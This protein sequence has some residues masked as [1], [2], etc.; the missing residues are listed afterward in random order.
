MVKKALMSAKIIRPRSNIPPTT[1]TTIHIMG[2]SSG[3]LTE[4]ETR[5][6][7]IKQGIFENLTYVG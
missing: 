4:K 5:T 7:W 6:V 1:P 3:Q 2:A